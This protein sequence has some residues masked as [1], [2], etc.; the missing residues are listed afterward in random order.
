MVFTLSFCLPPTTSAMFEFIAQKTS[1]IPQAKKT[2]TSFQKSPTKF[3]H[4]NLSLSSCFKQLIYYFNTLQCN[5]FRRLVIFLK[6]IF[7][8]NRSR[9]IK[10]SEISETP[11]VHIYRHLGVFF[12]FGGGGGIQKCKGE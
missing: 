5:A 6:A 10:S 7:F 2:K 11:G 1:K 4:Q 9:K 8:G 12:F 3:V